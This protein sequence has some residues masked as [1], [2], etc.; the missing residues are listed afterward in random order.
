[1]TQPAAPVPLKALQR[2]LKLLVD[3]L[4]DQSEALPELNAWLHGQYDAA[5]T[6]RRT[7]GTYQS[8]RDE[9]VELAA[10][11]WLLG[12]VFVRFCEDNHLV[13]R[14]WIGGPG[15][16]DAAVQAKTAYFQENFRHNDRHWLRHAFECLRKLRA[17]AAL[18]DEHNPVWRFDISADAA[19]ALL[20]FWQ[21]GAGLATFHSLDTRFLGDLYQDLSQDARKRYALLQ[22]PEFVEEFILNLTLDESLLEASDR[23]ANAIGMLGYVSAFAGRGVEALR[24]VDAARREC[25]RPDPI[26]RAR[27]LGS[28]A[29]A[30]AAD[31]D[32]NRF[33]RASETAMQLLMKYRRQE[34]PSFLYYLAPEQ[35]AAEAGQGL[36]VL[37]ER[38]TASRKRLLTE[39]IDALTGA[40]AGLAQSAGNQEQ[41][42]YPRSGLL[43]STFL[44]KVGDPRAGHEPADLR[45]LVLTHFHID[46]V[47]TAA[48]VA[49]WGGVTVCAHRADAPVIRGDQVGPPRACGPPVRG[50]MPCHALPEQPSRG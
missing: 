9:Q 22:T 7:G 6:A 16:V 2:Q 41:Q 21:R 18:F 33:R 48:E 13:N 42:Q 38:T 24:L 35:L 20:D 36:V 19:A 8:W 12:T 3:D 10:V 37:A 45:R 29:T 4:R 47:G 40:V 28:E 25:G 49:A 23:A 15:G 44:A 50:A 17:T 30:A 1:V 43:P 34:V 46:H 11:A 27:L 31:G 39:A 26:L 5:Y 32:L 14:R